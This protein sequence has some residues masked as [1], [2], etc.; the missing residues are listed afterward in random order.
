MIS[1]TQVTLENEFRSQLQD[2]GM[3]FDAVT[4]LPNHTSFRAAL[5]RMTDQST[6][7]GQEFALIWID[8]LNLR[9]EYS[10]SGDEGAVRLVCTVADTLR[11]CLKTGELICRFSDRCFLLAIRRDERIVSRLNS[12][13]SE[14]SQ[15]HLN[16]WEGKPEIAKEGDKK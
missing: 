2:F 15:L 9:R 8:V 1:G 16:G 5:R 10:I 6:T 3:Q 11:P 4:G 12:I 7:F 14:C 13:I